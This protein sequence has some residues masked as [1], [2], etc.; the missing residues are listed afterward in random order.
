MERTARIR[1]WSRGDIIDIGGLAWRFAAA[2]PPS[3]G[4]QPVECNHG[5]AQTLQ[6]Q[7]A[8]GGEPV[9]GKQRDRARTM[10]GNSRSDTKTLRL[11]HWLQSTGVTRLVF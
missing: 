11:E 8:H 4:T 2:G 10:K 3:I 5:I 1:A 9:D 7:R 6:R